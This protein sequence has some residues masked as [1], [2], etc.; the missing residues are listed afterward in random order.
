MTA[1]PPTNPPGLEERFLAPEGWRWH[2]FTTPRGRKIRFGTCAPKSRVPDAIVVGLQGLSEFTEKY[3]ELARDLQAA[4]L[5][6]WMMDWYGQG[7]SGRRFTEVQ[8]RHAA[9][10]D[11][12]VADLHYFIT[13]YIKH[14]AVHPEVGRIPLVM[15][16]HSMGGN[17]GLRYLAQYP[18][19]FAAASFTAPLVGLHALREWPEWLALGVTGTCG[20]LMGTQTVGFKKPVWD[21][22]I[23]ADP[24]RNIFSTDETR[25]RVHNAWCLH[26]A[27]LQTGPVTYGWVNAAT[28]SCHRLHNKKLI[29]KIG[30]PCLFAAA[31]RE[32][33]VDNDAVRRAVAA[34]PDAKLLEFPD[35]MH[36]ILMERDDIRG[37]FLAAFRELLTSRGIKEKLKPF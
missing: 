35:S 10:F 9:T 16:G 33:L 13:E 27:A 25:R 5:S 8:K 4:N 31:G 23:R 20:A 30:I 1:A 11:D 29:E 7:K 36:E 14:S 2:G 3:F 15:L 26:D 17:I 28:R 18:N 6:F 32:A 34:L 12:D 22:D 19:V 24:A 37:P 21:E